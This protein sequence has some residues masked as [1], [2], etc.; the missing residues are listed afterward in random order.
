[1]T[2]DKLCQRL[3]LYPRESVVL[4]L[5]AHLASEQVVVRCEE[6]YRLACEW[7]LDSARRVAL[8]ETDSEEPLAAASAVC[9]PDGVSF[10]TRLSLQ[11]AEAIALFAAGQGR[12]ESVAFA[13]ADASGVRTVVARQSFANS[14]REAP[15]EWSTALVLAGCVV[16]SDSV[17]LR[18]ESLGGRWV[19]RDSLAVNELVAIDALLELS[20]AAERVQSI[21]EARLLAERLAEAEYLL[22]RAK[23]DRYPWFV[24]EAR[25]RIKRLTRQMRKFRT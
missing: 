18:D 9:R 22:R 21:V 14:L 10:H 4:S 3:L 17:W 24:A 19:R 1:M 5:V 16:T 20:S 15:R 12:I 8:G 7:A 23:V 6:D 13:A 11:F 2:H 25:L